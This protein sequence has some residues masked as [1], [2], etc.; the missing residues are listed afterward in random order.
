LDDPDDWINPW[1]AAYEPDSGLGAGEWSDY[2]VPMVSTHGLEPAASSGPGATQQPQPHPDTPGKDGPRAKPV[3]ISLADAVGQKPGTAAPAK[4]ADPLLPE[5]SRYVAAECAFR[6]SC[7]V[8]ECATRA[9]V[10]IPDPG[11]STAPQDEFRQA[12]T[13]RC[14]ASATIARQSLI[15]LASAQAGWDRCVK[16][17]DKEAA[18]LGT[19]SAASQ[20]AKG[21]SQVPA[22]YPRLQKAEEDIQ[23]CVR[24]L[25]KSGEPGSEPNPD[26]IGK[27]QAFASVLND[28]ID[29]RDGAPADSMPEPD[30]E[31]PPKKTRCR[32]SAPAVPC[33]PP[34]PPWYPE[35]AFS[36]DLVAAR[37]GASGGKWHRNRRRGSG[38]SKR[39][40]V[41][42]L[43]YANPNE[44]GTLRSN[45]DEPKDAR[46]LSRAES[47]ILSLDA[48]I[49]GIGET[50]VRGPIASARTRKAFEAAGWSPV[51]AEA[52]ASDDS[53]KGNYGGAICAARQHISRAPIN[54]DLGPNLEPNLNSATADLAGWN[55]AMQ[56]TAVHIY[57]GYCRH[58][59]HAEQLARIASDTNGGKTPFIWMSDFNRSPD[60]IAK[61]GWLEDL[62]AVI[63]RPTGDDVSCT[64]LGGSVIDYVII[65]AV[66]AQY[67]RACEY[68]CAAPWSPHYGFTLELARRASSFS[69]RVLVRRSA[70]LDTPA[71]PGKPPVSWSE[72]RERADST[73]QA[74]GPLVPLPEQ[75]KL[76]EALGCGDEATRIGERYR[77][78]ARTL[79][80]QE[81]SRRGVALGSQ[82]LAHGRASVPKF[83][84][85]PM[86]KP[87]TIVPGVHHVPGGLGPV[88]QLWFTLRALVGRLLRD[89]E[90]TAKQAGMGTEAA[91]APEQPVA[92]KRRHRTSLELILILKTATPRVR[93]AWSRVHSAADANAARIAVWMA[94]NPTSG[95]ESIRAAHGTLDRLALA[96]VKRHHTGSKERWA[97]WV[98]TALM[99]GASAAHKWAN[100]VN[101]PRLRVYAPGHVDPELTVEHHTLAWGNIW[102]VTEAGIA[103][104]VADV[105][106]LR[107]EQLGTADAAKWKEAVN[108]TTMRKAAA[109]YSKRTG[110]GAD[111]VGFTDIAG[112][113]DEAL[114]ELCAIMRD[115]IDQLT[116]PIQCLIT[117]MHLIAKKLGGS[118]A[119]ALATTFVRLLLTLGK[120][121]V[122]SWDVEAA[123]PGDTGKPG[124]SLELESV[125]RHLKIETAQAFNRHIV[126]I[127]WDVE[128][129]YDTSAVHHTIDA[130][131]QLDF[132]ESQLTLGLVS[133]RAPRVLNC[134]GC[135]GRTLPS[136]GRSMLAGCT[137]ATSMARARI[138]RVRRELPRDRNHVVFQQVDDLTQ[139]ISD[140]SQL[141]AYRS[142][143]SLGCM[144]ADGLVQDGYRV[145][146]KS[147]VIAS[148]RD[149]A[150]RVATHLKAKGH[151]VK[152]A[153]S[154]DDVGVTTAVTGKRAVTAQRARIKAT[155]T[156]A[157][158]VGTLAQN[159]WKAAKMHNSGC[160]PAMKYA[161]HA[162]GFAPGAIK[163]MR[164]VAV[165]ALP[166][167]GPQP[168]TTTIITWWLG[169]N[170]DPA[171]FCRVGQV[172]TW[173]NLWS[174][175][176]RRDQLMAARAWR[177]SL[178]ELLTQHGWN[179]V[180][181]PIRATIRTLADAGW[182]PASAT[183][184]Y[185]EGKEHSATIDTNQPGD[186]QDI[187]RAFAASVNKLRW[188]KAA[189]HFLGGGLE[190]G[191]PPLA[192]ATRARRRLIK[193]GD[194]D[195]AHALDAVVCGA[196]WMGGRADLVRRCPWC[197]AVETPYHRYWGCPKL[198]DSDDQHIK[199]SQHLHGQADGVCGF[200]RY[201]CLWGRAILPAELFDYGQ[202]CCEPEE[203]ILYESPGFEGI[204]AK[205]GAFSRTA[206]AAR[207]MPRGWRS[208]TAAASPLL[209]SARRRAK[210]TNTA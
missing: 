69:K 165:A 8:W 40:D 87:A 4:R 193:A 202:L 46:P 23:E 32:K 177:L 118:R 47:F 161:G 63:I 164:T 61:L 10:G 80:H 31:C 104:A 194:T 191:T 102:D 99:N 168:C 129:F 84:T 147:T 133:H 153:A 171:H 174:K 86:L 183:K 112:A 206:Q 139:M 116:L 70:R 20:P 59:Q 160:V 105:A 55:V 98:A 199:D 22:R 130:A 208:T 117:L 142:A 110:I 158:R 76:V 157:K 201:P 58:G 64:H 186:A 68:I 121:D 166:N 107:S 56:G 156:R 91:A 53:E 179:Q 45:T 73:I 135:W 33:G 120:D 26:L 19:Q 78:W 36:T 173:I 42:K 122:R 66:L 123:L 96:E 175:L 85:V 65:S 39:P 3:A 12:V 11:Q 127:L 145:S 2:D 89:A 200:D 71:I 97:R 88:G 136:T 195:K 38:V 170:A 155:A 18:A 35:G 57:A 159:S 125:R 126:M 146:S 30:A 163:E 128:K 75:A 198:A 185:S 114:S 106:A 101:K 48:D 152:I 41:L 150:R 62:N 14:Q 149:L 140:E 109:A 176:D 162:Q 143:A 90:R 108:P 77:R 1:D 103:Q 187:V 50:H 138:I 60:D 148:S 13:L 144:L 43:F 81:F 137:Y 141:G 210:G 182:I 134:G 93:D 169:D 67:V 119:I 94:A 188:R 49:I 172:S 205:T 83:R 180:A 113:T 44:L 51:M 184:W 204:I 111:E 100:A 27:C 192:P 181:G 151:P 131:K 189:S 207:A 6:S 15:S 197:Q 196:C 34:Q 95:V 167:P 115:C 25:V 124:V 203:A 209:T 21:G 72:A 17:A 74:E 79:E 52:R 92:S 154:A 28:E 178:P 29:K 9:L 82:Q 7:H 132:P 37:T 54:A 16:L 5:Y 190:T 24:A